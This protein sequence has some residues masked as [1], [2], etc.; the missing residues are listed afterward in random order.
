MPVVDHIGVAVVA[1]FLGRT[2]WA[3]FET[4]VVEGEIFDFDDFIALV[5]SVAQI[6]NQGITTIAIEASA[7][8]PED[9]A[10]PVFVNHFLLV[11]STREPAL[12][13]VGGIFHP[14]EIIVLEYVLLL[15]FVFDLPARFGDIAVGLIVE[16]HGEEVG[17]VG[18]RGHCEGRIAAA[19]RDGLSRCC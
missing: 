10:T 4:P 13:A 2:I 19:Y 5:I 14:V 15:G 17:G 18:E 7:N 1:V 9:I 8:K 6:I 16:A 3:P 11:I 12:P